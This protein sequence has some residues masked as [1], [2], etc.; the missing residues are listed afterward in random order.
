MSLDPFF[1]PYYPIGSF[2]S[3]VPVPGVDPDTGTLVSICFN[4]AWLPYVIGSLKQL[5]ID[6]T[7]DTS[8]IS[9]LQTTIGQAYTLIALF[10]AG[11]CQVSSP[12]ILRAEPSG[13]GIQWSTDNGATWNTIDLN[14][15]IS[16]IADNVFHT[17]L[18]NAIS[19]GTIQGGTTQYPP[20]SRPS[21]GQCITYH[22]RLAPGATW[23]V[24]SLVQS[25]DTIHVTNAKGGWS[26]GELLWFCPDGTDYRL[27][28]CLT[29]TVR[30]EASD[31]L[32]TAAHMQIIG[33]FQGVYFDPMAS[34]FTLPGAWGASDVYLQA[35]TALTSV[36]SGDVT[37]DVT[38]CSAVGSGW[39]NYFDFS[40]Q[41]PA[42]CTITYGTIDAFGLECADN[43]AFGEYLTIAEVKITIPSAHE[44]TGFAMYY[45]IDTIHN[46]GGGLETEAG[47]YYTY[48]GGT[49]GNPHV[50]R[51]NE[52]IGKNQLFATTSISGNFTD[53]TFYLVPGWD[54]HAGVYGGVGRIKQIVLRGATT[55]PFGA[56][57]CA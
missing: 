35:N 12:T 44:V 6:R 47:I 1:Q 57:D 17:D 2:Q 28:Q 29:G 18:S 39:C 51:S 11:L 3:P 54:F 49:L 9:V 5:V 45:D 38:V 41:T 19:D 36:P 21:A 46:S 14:L 52:V 22:A 20:Q 25:G 56:S 27:G 55:S 4:P 43:P 50:T 37:F 53:L 32:Q 26:I 31:P 34:T 15:C 16:V 40:D 30:H 48:N 42:H 33:L 10:E 24:P 13:C 8:D 23:H 7:W